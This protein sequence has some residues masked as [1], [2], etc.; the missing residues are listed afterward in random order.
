MS[1]ELCWLRMISRW[2]R[3]QDLG[4][5]SYLHT[6]YAPHSMHQLVVARGSCGAEL[7]ICRGPQPLTGRSMWPL[8]CDT[9]LLLFIDS[10]FE[11]DPQRSL[12]HLLMALRLRQRVWWW[13]WGRKGWWVVA[14]GT[15]SRGSW[16]VIAEEVSYGVVTSCMSCLLVPHVVYAQRALACPHRP[17]C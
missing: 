17:W 15:R 13:G 3:Q 6:L 1:C 2:R 8:Y 5:M 4:S 12:P 14:T 7:V 10:S 16:G 11:M 9:L